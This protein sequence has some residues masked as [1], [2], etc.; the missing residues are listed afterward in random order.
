M[1]IKHLFAEILTLKELKG[2]VLLQNRDKVEHSTWGRANP[3]KPSWRY[4]MGFNG[5]M[6][7]TGKQRRNR[8]VKV[9]HVTKDVSWIH[10][11]NI[12][13]TWHTCVPAEA[14]AGQ[15]RE[16][17]KFV[18]NHSSGSQQF[19]REREQKYR[20]GGEK[21]GVRFCIRHLNPDVKPSEI[22]AFVWHF[23]QK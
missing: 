4:S 9:Q 23:K 5:Q 17:W 1:M 21:R 13:R 8:D 10:I 3:T 20:N 2:K 14:A 15:P 6:A 19:G 22:S 12:V 18:L 7:E 16:V 11:S